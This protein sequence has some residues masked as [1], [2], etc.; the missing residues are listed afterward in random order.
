MFC[1]KCGAEVGEQAD[2]CLSCGAKIKKETNET[3]NESKTGLG[4]VC[5]L[6][7]GLIG[8]IIG[9]CM[10]PEGTVAR[11]T[12]MKAWG[13]TFGVS[14]AVSVIICIIYFVVIGNLI[15]SLGSM[16]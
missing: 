15:G 8:L 5:G 4:V 7:L 10:F 1:P 16:V 14:M 11:K 13:I 6:F 12:F 9:I 2:V 3:H